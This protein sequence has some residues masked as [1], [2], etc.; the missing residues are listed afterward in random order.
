MVRIAR[1]VRM[2]RKVYQMKI[3][4]YLLVRKHIPR[5]NKSKCWNPRIHEG[6]CL[7]SNIERD[8]LGYLKGRSSDSTLSNEQQGYDNLIKFMDD[9]LKTV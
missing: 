3:R 6:S 2:A 5:V 9:E 4:S 7:Y 1:K 8:M